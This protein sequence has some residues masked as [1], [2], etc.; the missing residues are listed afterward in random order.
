ME[1]HSSSAGGFC[2]LEDNAAYFWDCGTINADY[3]APARNTADTI[4][5]CGNGVGITQDDDSY[6]NTL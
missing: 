5:I 6:C 2:L 3:A 4:V 1:D